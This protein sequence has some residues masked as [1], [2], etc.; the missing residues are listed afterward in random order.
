M[1]HDAS[2]SSMSGL[3]FG[4]G[5]PGRC[6]D[7]RVGGAVV[8]YDE[9]AE[10]WKMWY[11]CRNRSYD[12]P[13]PPTLGSGR[14]GLAHSDDGINWTRVAGNQ[15]YGSV[16]A[17]ADDPTKFDS[18][19]LGLTDVTRRNGVW[20][21]WYFGGD[22]S[23]TDSGNVTIGVMPGLAMRCGAATSPDGVNWTRKSGPTPSGALFERRNDEIYAAWPTVIDVEGSYLMLYTSPDFGMTK[24]RMR[25]MRSSDGVAWQALPDPTLHGG[26]PANDIGG[27]VTR[28]IIANPCP[29]GR[30][31]L[32]AYT[33][34]DALHQRAILLAE[35]DDG[36]A[37]QRIFHQPI[38]S[39]GARGQWDD[40][41]VAVNSLIMRDDALWIYYYGFRSLG[42]DDGP[43]GI[44]LAMAPLNQR[45]HFQ[46]V[47]SE[48]VVS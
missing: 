39:R 4:P 45:H 17:P 44:G 47:A 28:S 42:A 3:I 12:R 32:M 19:H 36:L 1:A 15:P 5:P 11:Y 37:W 2:E 18:G 43:R 38:L 30:R 23:L 6:D 31:W 21:M 25:A 7:F 41:G 10:N 9:S 40:K 34:L 22:R 20:V 33:G 16:L 48:A 26:L 8:S 24:M 46:R 35:S 27:I 29:G 13:A 14:V